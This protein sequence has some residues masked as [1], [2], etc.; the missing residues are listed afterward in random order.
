MSGIPYRAWLRAAI[1]ILLL[2]AL[3]AS[4]SHAFDASSAPKN[5]VYG[6]ANGIEF[7]LDVYAAMPA[8]PSQLRP[9]L[10]FFHGGGWRTGGKR[11]FSRQ[12]AILTQQ[13]RMVVISADYPTIENPITSTE[14]A[15]AATCWVR[16]HAG[17]LGIDLNHIA[18]SGGSA[19]GQL[20]AAVGLPSPLAVAACADVSRPLANAIVLFNP[21][22]Q[23]AGRWERK[24]GM[25]LASVSPLVNLDNSLPPTLILQGDADRVAP[26][27]IARRFVATARSLGNVDV[28][29]IE[30]PGR[31]HGFFNRTENGDLKATVSDLMRFLKDLGWPL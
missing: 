8:D 25:R 3:P 13:T 21:V 20:A 23:L 16:K 4:S 17:E 30:F 2:A 11:Q 5:Y 18:V 7:S 24:F 28:E 10:I 31:P 19:G 22:L 12:A 26:I 6:K 1:V 15:L 14:Y 27:G 9:A 29:L